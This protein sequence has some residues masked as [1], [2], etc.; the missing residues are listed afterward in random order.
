MSRFGL[1]KEAGHFIDPR[2]GQVKVW[3]GVDLSGLTARVSHQALP[4]I[5]SKSQ[6]P[7]GIVEGGPKAM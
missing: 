5:H 4:V 7:Q 2:P 6:I 1:L 3:M